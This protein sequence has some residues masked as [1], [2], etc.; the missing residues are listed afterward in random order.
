M[1]FHT[2]PHCRYI[3][4]VSQHSLVSTVLTDPSGGISWGDF[5]LNNLNFLKCVNNVRIYT[6]LP[7]NRYNHSTIT[8]VYTICIRW[9]Y[10]N[11]SKILI[12]SL[13]GYTNF[14]Y[15]EGLKVHFSV[16]YIWSERTLMLLML[17]EVYRD[18][19]RNMLRWWFYE[20]H[21]KI[22]FQGFYGLHSYSTFLTGVFDK[23]VHLERV[24]TIMG[25]PSGPQ[26]RGVNRITTRKSKKTGRT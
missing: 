17:D 12:T 7:A 16:I 18:T 4:V 10:D 14:I 6:I 11:L 15:I 25:K 20:R 22:R 1:N 26:P 5:R 21:R 24:V 2:S 8:C 13:N 19:E 3:Y 9:K 23:V